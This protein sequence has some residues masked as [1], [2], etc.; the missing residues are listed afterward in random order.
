MMGGG[1]VSKHPGEGSTF[2]FTLPLRGAGDPPPPQT[3]LESVALLV[4]HTNALGRQLIVRQL[5]GWQRRS[6]PPRTTSTA[7]RALRTAEAPVSRLRCADR[8]GTRI[9]CELDAI[10]LTRTV[11]ST[12]GCA[13][14][15]R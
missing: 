4:V 9:A 11:A 8:S 2:W 3:A 14:R 7:L 13:R 6:P 15:A 5:E 10:E 1:S 12:R